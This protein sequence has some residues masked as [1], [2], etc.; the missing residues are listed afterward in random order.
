MDF[1][2]ERKKSIRKRLEPILAGFDPEL[3]FIT[4]FLDSGR[5]NLA[6]VAEKGD[7]PLVLRLD[8]LR[9][10]S[11]PDDE[12]RHSLAEQLARRRNLNLTPAPPAS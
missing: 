11:M 10:V 3:K 8:F 4:V 7:H 9:Y 1:S 2:P 5:K 12:I 6:V